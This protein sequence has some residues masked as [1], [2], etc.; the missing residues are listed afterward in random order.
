MD[1]DSVPGNDYMH[2]PSLNV[3]AAGYAPALTDE[4][5]AGLGMLVL[6]LRGEL[7]SK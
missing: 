7:F 3:P 5:R 4:V 2:I 1:F 6:S